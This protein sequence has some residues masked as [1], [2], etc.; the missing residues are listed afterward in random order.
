MRYMWR[1]IYKMEKIKNKGG[2]NSSP[3]TITTNI[4]IIFI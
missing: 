3:T 1:N 4:F 2:D